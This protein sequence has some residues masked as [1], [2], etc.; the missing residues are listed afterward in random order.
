MNLTLLNKEQKYEPVPWLCT[1]ESYSYQSCF[2]EQGTNFFDELI[3]NKTYRYIG[4]RDQKGNVWWY[5][6]PFY[7]KRI[8]SSD[9]QVVP[10]LK[11][12]KN[13]LESN[14]NELKE[15]AEKVYNQNFDIYEYDRWLFYDMD[16]QLGDWKGNTD[17]STLSQIN[18][19]IIRQLTI[20]FNEGKKVTY[21]NKSISSE[22]KEGFLPWPYFAYLE[23]ISIDS[24]ENTLL[25]FTFSIII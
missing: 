17:N 9:Y 18:D 7:A 11:A 5:I 15:L 13:I 12:L 14:L 24:K 19:V 1:T 2:L 20:E 25:R 21:L 23:F 8:A 22:W 10:G 16:E 4:G 6:G 3:Q